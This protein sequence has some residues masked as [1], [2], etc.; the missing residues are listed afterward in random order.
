MSFRRAREIIQEVAFEYGVDYSELVG[1]GK[2]STTRTTACGKAAMLIR[3]ELDMPAIEMAELF[4]CDHTTVIARIKR[5]E[6]K[7]C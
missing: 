4:G 6:G 7:S 5:Y 1:P 2:K 3:D